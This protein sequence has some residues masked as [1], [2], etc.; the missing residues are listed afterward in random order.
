MWITSSK[1]RRTLSLVSLAHDEIRERTDTPNSNRSA[2]L[3][4]QAR[5]QEISEPTHPRN[6]RAH[7]LPQMRSSERRREEGRQRATGQPIG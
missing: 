4:R 2:M 6:A 1:R 3:E 7:T 5:M